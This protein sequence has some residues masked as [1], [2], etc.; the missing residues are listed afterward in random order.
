[1]DWFRGHYLGTSQLDLTDPRISPLLAEDLS[2]LPCA[3]VITAG[4][5][6]LRDEGETYATAMRDAGVLVDLRRMSSLTH[7]FASLWT[8]GGASAFAMAGIISALRAHLCY[9]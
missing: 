2:A 4:F 5:D 8:L 9:V 3:L 6:P 1:M 7:G